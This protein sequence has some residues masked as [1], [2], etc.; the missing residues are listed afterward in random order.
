MN[1]ASTWG[2]LEINPKK[3]PQ[4][5][6][7]DGAM[8]FAARFNREPVMVHVNEAD[9]SVE[10]EGLAVECPGHVPLKHYRFK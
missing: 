3:T 4:Q 7:A 6:I 8:V 5:S 1:E 2:W 9:R 10:V